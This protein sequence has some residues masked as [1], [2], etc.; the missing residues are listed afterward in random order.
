MVCKWCGSML[1]AVLLANDNLNISITILL[2]YQLQKKKN[3]EIPLVS[4]LSTK[5]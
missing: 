3:I 5:M 1:M 2:L 4:Q